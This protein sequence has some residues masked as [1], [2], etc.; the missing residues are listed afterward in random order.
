MSTKIAVFFTNPEPWGYPFTK[1]EYWTSYQELSTEVWSQG[2]EFY[3]TRGQDTYTGNGNFIKSW[4]IVNGSLEESG[5]LS[6]DVIYDKG[7]FI[8]DKTIPI[9]NSEEIND[10]CTDKWKTY[11]M[12]TH[13]FPST[14]KVTDQNQLIPSC[15]LMKTEMIVIKPVDGEEGKDVFIGKKH[16]MAEIRVTKPVLVQEFLDSSA[17]ILGIT[18]GIHDFRIALLNGEIVYSFLRT[19]PPNS[20]MANISLGGSVKIFQPHEIPTEFKDVAYEVDSK[21]SQFGRRLY[22]VDMAL[23][24]QGI[25]I[26]ELNSRLGL[27]KNE[28]HEVFASYKKKLAKMLIDMAN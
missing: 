6:V 22:G 20:L 21:L 23:T 7:S 28:R 1:E 16:E 3:I 27:Q 14:V 4:R 11:Q 26:I 2:A 12:F 13:L 18:E 19:P 24:P 5:P 9:L 17:G 15:N 25:K 8:T 10:I